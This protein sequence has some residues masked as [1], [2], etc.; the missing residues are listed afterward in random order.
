[1]TLA[2]ISIQLPMTLVL[3]K[4]VKMVKWW[5]SQ[6]KGMYQASLRVT[7]PQHISHQELT[8]GCIHQNS[9]ISML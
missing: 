2:T 5:I 3:V 7:L 6:P 9:S 1:M 8:V 4:N